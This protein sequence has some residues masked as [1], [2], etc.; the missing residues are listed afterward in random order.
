MLSDKYGRPGWKYP[1]SNPRIVDKASSLQRKQF[2]FSFS[3][4]TSPIPD[5]LGNGAYQRASITAIESKMGLS[6]SSSD[7]L[8]LHASRRTPISL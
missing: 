6:A 8:A 5:G 3:Q 2:C 1:P 4:K 7:L